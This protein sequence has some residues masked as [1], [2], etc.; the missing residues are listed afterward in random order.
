MG[1]CAVDLSADPAELEAMLDI[2]RVSPALPGTSF[3]IAPGDRVAVLIDAVNKDASTESYDPENPEVLRRLEPALWGLVPA[4]APDRTVGATMFNAP[5]E[6]AR[7]NPAFAP[8]VASRRAAVPATGYY[9]WHTGGDGASSAQFVHS[10]DGE[11]LLLAA[12]YEWWRDPALAPDDPARWVL[13][14]TVLTRASG[15]PLALIHGRMPVLL[16]P[17]LLEDWLD[18]RTPGSAE[19]LEAVSEAAL[20][21]AEDVEFY[22]VGK[23]VAD[24]KNNTEALLEP[25]G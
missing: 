25:V 12:L 11:P 22:E 23:A 5:I 21:L 17:G 19:L 3:N 9:V 1:P 13:S 20:D 15:G 8:A 16:E 10:P 7:E 2:H 4:G 14:T 18:P 6:S 24:V